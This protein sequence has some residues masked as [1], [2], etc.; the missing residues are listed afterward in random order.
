[1][2]VVDMTSSAI[3]GSL[4]GVVSGRTTAGEPIGFKGVATGAADPRF[5]QSLR[6]PRLFGPVCLDL[7]RS[8]AIS[9]AIAARVFSRRCFCAS[10]SGDG[11]RHVPIT[12]EQEAGPGIARGA[13]SNT[14]E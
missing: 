13:G 11:A 3:G 1:M 5:G 8:A 14:K 12:T 7:G 10:P 4:P 2:P 6:F 9:P